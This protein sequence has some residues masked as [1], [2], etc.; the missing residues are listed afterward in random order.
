VA[1]EKGIRHRWE[2]LSLLLLLLLL[3][4][5][6]LLIISAAA[7]AAWAEAPASDLYKVKIEHVWIPMKDGVRLAVD[8]YMPEERKPDEKFPAF[9]QYYPYR[10]DDGD[11]R[12]E[13]AMNVYFAQRGYVGSC[14]DV[15]GTGQSEGHVPDRE[16]SDQET[17]DG[18]EVIAWLA[19]Q[20]WSTG[21][22]GMLG[23]SWGGFSAIQIAMRQ[24]PALKALIIADATEN[25]YSEDIHYIHG[26]THMD[27]YMVG[28]DT[29]NA[30][31]PS[32][33]YPID[34][35]TLQARFDS[36]PWS[37]L[38][39]RHRRDGVFWRDQKRNLDAI[40]VPVFIIGSFMDGYRDTVPR[41]LEHLKTPVKAIVG[42]WEHHY[43]HD[44]NP[45]PEFEW[46]E[47]GV[48]W[49][50][51][52]LKGKETGIM[53]EPRLAVYMRHWY[54][55]DPSLTTL[56]DIPGEWR[57]ER[58]WPPQDQKVVTLY[59]Q[60]SHSLGAEPPTRT[61]HDLK[62]VP[63]AGSDVAGYSLWEGDMTPDQR[64][65]DAFSLVYDTSPVHQETAVL[66]LPQ[67]LLQVSATAPLADWYVRLSDIAPDGRVTLVAQGGISGAMRDSMT[68]PQDLEPGKIYALRV[69]M[70]FTSWVF[71]PGHRM[72]MA[73]SNATW[74][75]IWPTPY[76]MTTSLYLGGES[77]LLLPT[78]PLKGPLLPPHFN[79]VADS[80]RP[81]HPAQAQTA[82]IGWT[83]YRTEFGEPARLVTGRKRQTVFEVED[84]HPELAS[85]SANPTFEVHLPGRDLVWSGHLNIRCDQ[86]NFYYSYV[87]ELMENGKLIR[88][89]K[90]EETIPR[91]HQ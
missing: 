67:A 41:F 20:P 58:T 82:D 88:E 78:V 10:K 42:P 54:P 24:P 18:E 38:Y 25:L 23:K 43:P 91:D 77:R 1:L 65:A 63:S 51:Q 7:C 79:P 66:G 80:D 14:V 3:C 74:P 81:P 61:V 60:P 8:L 6:A 34:E 44:A 2:S 45:G 9:F 17:S 64:P 62:Y 31:S 40:P 12:D 22:V 53:E 73:V 28:I 47:L 56:K 52:W 90:W 50:D 29:H 33:D 69:P 57:S 19:R 72:R 27:G 36:P 68:D 59:P 11:I 86:A 85:Y 84:E 71:E 26:M 83:V 5:F 48:R 70:R 89:K 46:R 55:P 13:C 16:Y 39:L 35:K 21:T 30:M 87:R 75:L 4:L 37:L 76:S 49:W 32:P 15:R